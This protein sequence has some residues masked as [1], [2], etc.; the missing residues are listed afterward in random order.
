MGPGSSYKWGYSLITPISRVLPPQLPRYF[1]PFL[2]A[3]GL[4]CETTA[5]NP[6]GEQRWCGFSGCHLPWCRF[7]G[8]TKRC[9][10]KTVWWVGGGVPSGDGG[11][12]GVVGVVGWLG[13][14]YIWK[15]WGPWGCIE[16]WFWEDDIWEMGLKLIYRKNCWWRL[17]LE[18]LDLEDLWWKLE[19]RLRT[20][21]RMRLTSLREEV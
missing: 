4:L 17:T 9:G 8:F 18:H 12:R 14:S 3:P 15:E 10:F 13:G 2:G 7:R 21:W 19:R 1:R 6:P 11:L 5:E 20:A 16:S